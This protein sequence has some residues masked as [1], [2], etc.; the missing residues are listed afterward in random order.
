MLVAVET[1][2]EQTV[3][4]KDWPYV[5]P[6]SNLCTTP[7]AVTAGMFMRSIFFRS[8]ALVEVM[9]MEHTMKRK[10]HNA[11]HGHELYSPFRKANNEAGIREDAA[12]HTEPHR[13]IQDQGIMPDL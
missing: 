7:N 4:Q 11:Q 10:K 8:E 9:T 1:I 2:V 6:S 13:N 3:N 5:N 12:C